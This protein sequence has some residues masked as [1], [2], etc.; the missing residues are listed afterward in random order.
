LETSGNLITG[1]LLRPVYADSKRV[2]SDGVTPLTTNMFTSP[3]LKDITQLRSGF[4]YTCHSAN[5][6]RGGDTDPKLR[7]VPELPLTGSAFRP[8]LFRPLRDYHMVDSAGNQVIP[9][10]IGD[11]I[12]GTGPSLAATGIS[13][14]FC[15][16]VTG[17]DLNRS[18]RRDG[19]ANTSVLIAS[20][21]EK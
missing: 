3:V 17:P 4:C 6:E 10:T 12:P 8:D 5:V 9:A 13:C 1:G 2:Q 21:I 20:T 18:F 14:D 16:N 7:E 11:Y 19:F 15:H